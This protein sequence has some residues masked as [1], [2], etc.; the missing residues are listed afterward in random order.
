MI[1]KHFLDGRGHAG[2]LR[3]TTASDEHY[4]R[5]ACIYLVTANIGM[6]HNV[7]AFAILKSRRGRSR[8]SHARQTAQYLCHVGFS[9]NFTNIGKMFMRD[10]T[11]IA[12][13]CQ[14]VE[15]SRDNPSED[16]ALQLLETSLRHYAESLNLIITETS[17]E[18]S[19]DTF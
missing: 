10:R 1:N 3:R 7:P 5:L 19:N 8:L 14:R 17:K 6:T 18:A 16:M 9:M 12:K 11:S 15:E 13:A 4:K 2:H